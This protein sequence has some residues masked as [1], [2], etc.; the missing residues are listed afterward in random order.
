[1]PQCTQCG[2]SILNPRISL[3]FPSLQ[4]RL[5]SELGPASVQP[6]EIASILKSVELDLEDFDAEIARLEHRILLLNTLKER[7]REYGNQVKMLLSP[8]R[9]LPDELLCE[10]FDL[11]CGM[12]H[13]FVTELPVLTA[14]TLRSAPAMSLS[15]VCSRWRRNALA[16]PSIWS[17]IALGWGAE[18]GSEGPWGDESTF[19]LFLSLARSLSR[20][21]T[22]ELNTLDPYREPSLGHDGHL[23]P[24]IAK[25]TEQVHRWQKFTLVE[26]GRC[27]LK[28]LFINSS[29]FPILEDMELHEFEN[30]N[31]DFLVGKA[32]N[33]KKLTWRGGS[34]LPV[35]ISTN[36]FPLIA[37]IDFCM[38][39]ALLENF[40][41]ANPNLISLTLDIEEDEDTYIGV[42][43]MTFPR[44]CPRMETLSVRN[45]GN[46]FPAKSVFSA[47]RCPSL[48]SLHL[49]SHIPYHW[50]TFNLFLAFVQRSSFPLTTLSMMHLPLSD[51]NLVYLLNHVPTLMNLSVHDIGTTDHDA[52]NLKLNR[53]PL[54]ERFI[55]SFHAYQTS[56]LR[57]NF[58]PIV[59]RLRSLT[60]SC[61]ARKFNDAAVMDMV[62]SRWFPSPLSSALNKAEAWN[63][64][65]FHVDCLREFTLIFRDRKKVDSAV[66]AP[67]EQLEK[68][69]MRAVVLW[70][71]IRL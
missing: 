63:L 54:T 22:I 60:L 68:N 71:S 6:E 7:H 64:S 44:T 20:P 43:Y 39:P 18:G 48:K 17:R 11:C 56:S 46:N 5:R 45:I 55:N 66:Y 26:S 70:S 42:E 50:N 41:E 61:G 29:Q 15:S 10:V 1:M 36:T 4:A 53:S 33:L 3:D 38:D 51:S 28:D 21:L 19:P 9:K 40:L 35:S 67:L 59:P 65:P 52:E 62:R 14:F 58:S 13:F 49:S 31:V 24:I 25:L 12:N 16:M 34:P 47:M 23:H 37:H 27:M 32:P 69:G 2:E 8:I 30:F 57:S